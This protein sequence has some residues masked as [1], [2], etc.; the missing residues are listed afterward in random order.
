[1]R[2]LAVLAYLSRS[3]LDPTVRGPRC[4]RDAGRV[5]GYISEGHVEDG[6]AIAQINGVPVAGHQGTGSITDMTIRTLLTLRGRF[7]PWRIVSLMHYPGE[8]STHARADHANYI[9][10][11]FSAPSTPGLPVH[12]TAIKHTASSPLRGNGETAS[13]AATAA[14]TAA[15][16]APAAEATAAQWD[17]LIARIGA[18]PAPNIPSKPSSASIRDPTNRSNAVSPV[19]LP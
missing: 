8:P 7:A 3:G 16:E 19:A 18:L 1:M 14:E 9:E 2:V 13:A 5:P 15:G 12:S 10:V 11:D 4:G 17:Q 6:V